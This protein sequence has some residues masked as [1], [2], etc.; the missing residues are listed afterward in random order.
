MAGLLAA[1]VIGL[2]VATAAQQNASGWAAELVALRFV[3]KS[4]AS[5][6]LARAFKDF[7]STRAAGPPVPSAMWFDSARGLV[8]V[9][10]EQVPDQQA[11][12]GYRVVLLARDL[13]P[14]PSASAKSVTGSPLGLSYASL[15]AKLHAD[16]HLARKNIV[17]GA[18]GTV[19]F[20]SAEDED[21]PPARYDHGPQSYL[22]QDYF[23]R[24]GIV[25]AYAYKATEN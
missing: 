1:V 13:A 25:V 6:A 19:V 9:C 14:P 15:L 4:G 5:V 8:E 24:D 10:F 21:P 2:P 11:N 18:D 7:A 12:C 20:V 22:F 3:S 17:R 23:L 16:D